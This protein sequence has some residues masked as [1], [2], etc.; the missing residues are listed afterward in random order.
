MSDRTVFTSAT[1]YDGRKGRQQG[2][3][4]VIENGRIARIDS[5]TPPQVGGR[6]IDLA[7]K[8]LMPGM[9][10]GH[11]HGEFL[12]IGPP[13][14]GDKTRSG[15]YLGT[16][17]PPA[18]LALQ[19]AAAMKTAL[20]SGVMRVV[21]A[22]CS[23][24]L[25]IQMKMALDSGLIEGP[26]LTPCSRHVITT[27]DGEDRGL[28]WRTP[29][30]VK[31]GVRRYGH[32]VIVDGVPDIIKAVREEISF[33]ADIIKIL[34]NGGHGFDWTPTYRGLLPD[35][36]RAVVQTAH[37]RDKRVRAHVTT[38]ESILE[39]I[40]AGV[41]ILDHCD[42]MDDECVEAMVKRGTFYVPTAL[43]AKLVCSAGQGQPLDQSK[44]GDRAW[45]NL[46]KMLPRANQ[47]GVK[48][49]PGDDYGSKGLPH[50]LGG[51]A[52]ELEM[53]VKEFGIPVEDV[54]RW[55]TAN[56]AEMSLLGD[57]T[58]TIEVGKAADLIVVNGDPAG[59]IGILTDP[60]RNLKAIIQN[61]RFVKDD[62]VAT[63]GSTAPRSVAAAD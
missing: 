2:M 50:E 17:K 27:G 28:W 40:D 13:E 57:E 26:H 47:A 59:D 25:D 33:G 52:R 38:R 3:T 55:T 9:S 14:F 6:R 24:N 49:V 10:V 32:N 39:C 41:D 61:G 46:L 45:A 18:V 23:N 5:G 8:T 15:W 43:I 51:Y 62:L 36:L 22:S 60:V 34:P 19:A 11:W 54:I 7:G 16:E 29:A 1:L 20:Y 56:G 31:D 63:E 58:G 44:S 48:I 30:P 4:V 53:Y 35:E 37:D 21:S 12:E 42:Y